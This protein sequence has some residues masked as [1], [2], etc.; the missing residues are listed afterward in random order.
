MGNGFVVT[1]SDLS[2]ILKQIK[3]AEHHSQA[4]L[5]GTNPDPTNDPYYCQ[6][7]V[8]PGPDQIPD[9]LTS[10]GLRTTSGACNNLIA[11]RDKFAA[12]DVPFPRLTTPDFRPAQPIPAGFPGAGNSTSYA[13]KSQ[14]S[15]VFDSQPR[16]ISNLI[17][18]QSIKNPAAVAAYTSPVRAQAG[19]SVAAPVAC[20]N[21]TVDPPLPLGCTRARTTL[22][23]PNVT[24][25]VGLS[26][27]FNSLFTFFG[28]FFDHGVDQT[29]KG[30]GTVFVP[31]LANDPLRTVGPDGVAGTGDEVPAQAAFIPLSRGQ[32][33]PGPDGILGNS[34][35]VQDATNTDSPW[36]DQS[37]TYTS[38]S[39]HQVFLREYAMNNANQPVSTGKLLGGIAN[40]NALPCTT[41]DCFND[42]N[43]TTGSISTWAATKKQAYEKL[44]LLLTDHDVTNIPMI[45][46]DPY[47]KFTPG[48]LRGLPQYVTKVP[49]DATH[50]N[51][52]A[53]IEGCLPT[54]V[55]VCG[56]PV[57]VP[58]NV[59]YFD[60]PFL[61]DIAHNADP[62]MVDTNND[63][64]PDTFPTPDTDIVANSNFAAQAPGTYDDEMLNDHFTCGDGRCNENIALS[65][66]HQVF[67]H[68][69]D[70]LV[71]YIKNVLTSDTSV[72][73]IAALPEW[74]LP[75]TQSPDGW[76][77]ER[78]FQAARFV[79]EMEYQHLVFEEFARKLVPA[80]RP[81]HV[82][83]PDINAAVEAEFAHAVYRL[84]HSML[85]ED[86]ARCAIDQSTGNCRTDADNSITLLHAF[87]NPPEFFNPAGVCDVAPCNNAAPLTPEQAAGSIV[88][89]SSDQVGNE[90]DE[91]ITNTLRNNLLGL[92]LDLATFNLARARSEGIPPLNQVR[93]DLFAQTNDG[94]LTP[95][96][97]WS[98]FGQ[99][100]KHPESLINFVAA[101]GKHPSIVAATSIDTKRAAAR[102]IVDPQ[103]GDIVPC[104]AGAF[105]FGT[106][107]NTATC[108]TGTD[109]RNVGGKTTTGLDD[110]DLWVGGLAEVTNLFGGLL[111]TTFNYVF[112]S[113]LE[114][115]QDGDRFYYLNRTPGMNLRTQ[116][117]GNSFAELIMRNTDGT[118]TLKADAFAT[119]DC[120]FQLSNLHGTAADFATLGA[121]VADDPTTTDCNETLLLT[122]FP[123]G[124]IAYKQR[125]TV[126]PSGINGQSVYNGVDSAD[127]GPPRP[128]QGWQRQRH[129]LGQRRQ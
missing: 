114:K 79:T 52:L 8:G 48:P 103:A 16:E 80:I 113:Q 28:Q 119:A 123:D 74:Q 53:L 51:G 2:F 129:H 84:G 50:P 99:H 64:T 89:G 15:I 69:H 9:Y 60:T 44:G 104:D 32:V 66:I 118:S 85:D 115:L 41:A 96:T 13:D 106:N 126:D 37:Q 47:G 127:R 31:L 19:N 17:V 124:T 33:Q 1:A 30:S 6:S 108:P 128:N 93:R 12:A 67:H 56:G 39:A 92:P 116:L 122:R 95:Y 101:Y 40:D 36:V 11:G 75:T 100:L 54:Q 107:G 90:I 25:D 20:T 59:V 105:M 97:D 110:V 26:P 63:G 88:M 55:A 35:D 24:T 73:G 91:F 34:D 38:H 121:N 83:S 57:A 94:Q 109:W 22:F 49:V 3:I 10:Y 78:L 70:R 61:T 4:F 112:Q 46:A 87:L 7:L 111:G 18:D 86:V 45:A 68:E 72:T 58:A 81:F 14:G 77:G 42:G 120:K 29:V 62:S 76:N 117:E 21:E 82:Y 98:D 5:S 125:N 71:D 43:A 23:I 27:P 65:T 102:A